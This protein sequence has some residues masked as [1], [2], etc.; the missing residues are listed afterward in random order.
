MDALAEAVRL[1]REFWRG[2]TLRFEGQHYRAVGLHAGPALTGSIGSHTRKEYTIIG[3][4]V[5]LAS[6]IE[7]LTKEHGAQILVSHSV[8]EALDKLP[9]HKERLGSVTVRGRS[10]PLD[11]FKLA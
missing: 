7:Q 9:I 10:A 8:A 5:N 2:G 11:L 4:T 6:R 1:I 3:D